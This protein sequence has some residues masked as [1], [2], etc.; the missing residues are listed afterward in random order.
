[1]QRQ[2]LQCSGAEIPG[3]HLEDLQDGGALLRPGGRQGGVF[4][5]NA[6]PH[7]VICTCPNK[8]ATNKIEIMA[9]MYFVSLIYSSVSI[10]LAVANSA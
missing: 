9:Q 1:M 5:L 10:I 4:L 6:K 7:A 2:R 3:Q 8:W